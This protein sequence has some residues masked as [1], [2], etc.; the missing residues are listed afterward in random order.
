MN[1]E[2]KVYT[3][4]Q[5]DEIARL[6]RFVNAMTNAKNNDGKKLITPTYNVDYIYFETN[7]VLS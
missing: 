3:K 7:A 6:D 5:V 1:Q 4:P 2:K